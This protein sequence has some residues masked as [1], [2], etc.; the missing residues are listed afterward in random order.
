MNKSLKFLFCFS[1]CAYTHLPPSPPFT[2][3]FC[4]KKM[5]REILLDSKARSLFLRS[6]I[7]RKHC[8]SDSSFSHKIFSPNQHALST[9]TKNFAHSSV[10]H[11]HNIC[12]IICCCC[13]AFNSLIILYLRHHRNHVFAVKNFHS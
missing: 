4:C 8:S 12:R 2:P 7:T 9:N 13:S 5:D 1:L 10:Y 6:F 11:T 3:L